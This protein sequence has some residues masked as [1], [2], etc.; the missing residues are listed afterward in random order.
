MGQIAALL[1]PFAFVWL[2]P[3]YGLAAWA[4]SFIAMAKWSPRILPALLFAGFLDWEICTVFWSSN[5]SAGWSDVLLILPI[6]LM[7]VVVNLLSEPNWNESARVVGRTFAWATLLSW[8]IIFGYSLWQ[9][10]W[11][12]YQDFALADRLG[13]HFQSLYLIAAAFLLERELWSIDTPKPFKILLV[14]AVLWALLGVIFL[15]NR[16]HLLVVPFL[17]FLRFLQ[18]FQRHPNLR[19]FIVRT[20][21]A[22]LLLLGLIVAF[23]PGT[24]RR[25]ID[26]KNELRS[27]SSMVDGKQTNPRVYLWKYGAEIIQEHP[28]LGVGNGAGE[29]ALH[30]KLLACDA[31]FYNKTTPYYL[32]EFP[33]D[34]H[35]IY[36]QSLAEGG[37]LGL[38]LLLAILG[39]GWY[40]SAGSLRIIWIALAFSGLTESLLEKQAGVFLIAFLIALTALSRKARP[41]SL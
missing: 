37:L 41:S 35:N 1:L 33:Y 25:I 23:L 40:E 3:V 11:V 2:S 9:L 16:I 12:N 28:F 18:L 30:E 7:G 21:F 36:L 10:G 32:H 8:T 6:P 14:M 5:A 26:L 29:E 4:L 20:L 17:V 39:W 15:S 27:T 24:Q 22:V 19:S 34:F 13:V 31:K 38:I